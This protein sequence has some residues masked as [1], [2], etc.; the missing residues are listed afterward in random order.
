MFMY[1]H[2]SPGPVLL[3]VRWN[4]N[5]RHREKD[6]EAHVMQ[7]DTKQVLAEGLQGEI[8]VWRS[9]VSQSYHWYET[10][11]YKLT[12]YMYVYSRMP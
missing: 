6:H 3:N 11:S 8:E 1:M 7:R 12:I 9:F 5:K 2:I 4:R 10:L